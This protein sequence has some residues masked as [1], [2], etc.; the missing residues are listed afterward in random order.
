[1]VG[2]NKRFATRKEPANEWSDRKHI[3]QFELR[4]QSV[5]AVDG[6]VVTLLRV[7]D[8]KIIDIYG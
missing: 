6:E 1:M 4:V 3:E 5:P 7:L 8:P 2:S